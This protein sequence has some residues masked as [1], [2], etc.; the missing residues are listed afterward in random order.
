MNKENYRG[1]FITIEGGEGVGKSSNI[2]FIQRWV[3]ENLAY[4]LVLTREPGGTPLAEEIRN[5]F[6]E[7][8]EELVDENT[9][10]LLVFAARAQH[11]AQLI[12][13]EL[14]NGHWV[15]SDRFTDATFAYQGGGRGLSKL[16]ITELEKIVQKELRPDL[17]ILLDLPVELGLSRAK[18]RSDFDRIEREQLSFFE[19]VR[20]AYLERAKADP[21][22]FVIIDASQSIE[23][24]QQDIAVALEN[25]CSRLGLTT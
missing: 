1:K 10:L 25:F 16:V 9:E 23:G 13:P 22:R 2:S 24:V 21:E 18:S 6:I 15:L 7:P 12:R 8:R 19:R 20:N 11:I 4:K 5:L 3:K 17:T 14:D